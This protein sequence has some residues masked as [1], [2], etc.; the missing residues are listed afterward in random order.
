MQLKKYSFIKAEQL[1]NYDLANRYLLKNYFAIPKVK[2]LKIK[3]S[4]KNLMSSIDDMSINK[5]DINFKIKSF[6]TF[7][8]FSSNIPLI[9]NNVIDNLTNQFDEI[10]KVEEMTYNE[11]INQ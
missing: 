1:V 2:K 3:I 9:K 11:Y 5:K 8:L 4:L 6:I 10:V 7:F